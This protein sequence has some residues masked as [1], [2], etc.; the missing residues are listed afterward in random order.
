M[1]HE[2]LVDLGEVFGTHPHVGMNRS[3]GS[4]KEYYWHTFEKKIHDHIEARIYSLM[5]RECV[6]VAD[7]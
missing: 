7:L 5:I 3:Y 4:Y 6:L 2:R 1:S